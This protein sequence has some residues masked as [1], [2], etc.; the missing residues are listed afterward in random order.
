MTFFFWKYG[1]RLGVIKGFLKL[2]DV[3][4]DQTGVQ[5]TEILLRNHLL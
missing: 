5:C 4:A 2:L 3:G 1:K